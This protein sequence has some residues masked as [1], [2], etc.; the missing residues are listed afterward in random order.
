MGA[1]VLLGAAI[2]AVVCLF[3]WKGN[4]TAN[5]VS[6]FPD[7]L[8]FLVLAVLTC[9]AVWF[10]ARRSQLHDAATVW[11]VGGTIAATAG[12]LFGTAVVLIG[13]AR[14][15]QSTPLLLAFGF[16]TA[17]GSALVCGAAASALVSRLLGRRDGTK[18]A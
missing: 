5:V 1:R 11:R 12:F 2:G 18:V 14:L 8:T 9:C 10:C 17:F 15:G 6:T 16:L 4:R 7:L 13:V 3:S